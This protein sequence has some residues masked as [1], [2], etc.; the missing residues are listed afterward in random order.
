MRSD[1]RLFD[2][3]R[4]A[5]PEAWKLAIFGL[6]RDNMAARKLLHRALL[7]RREQRF[8][9]QYLRT[10]SVR[11]WRRFGDSAETR[12][13]T[14][15]V[16]EIPWVLSRHNGE[17]HVLDVGSS[18]APPVYISALTRLGIKDL[19]GVD[20]AN[21]QLPGLNVVHA[22][23]RHMPFDRG[24]F[25]LI[26]CISTLEHIG[27]DG[28]SQAVEA[29]DLA[30]LIEMRRVLSSNG[31]ILVSVPFGKAELHPWFRQYDRDGWHALIEAAGLV[32]LEQ[33]FYR[34]STH[35]G[36]GETE[37]ANLVS[38]SYQSDGAPAA[39]GLLCA[40]LAATSHLNG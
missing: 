10:A 22:D 35:A 34:Y 20:I 23:V 2:R 39:T 24:H 40:S 33:S 31:R 38:A 16:V 6:I 12:G 14:E 4:L 13:F 9:E 25:E 30:A 7:S 1:K 37:A 27:R 5:I 19:V 15:R 29:G 32:A 8:I 17:Q 18:F 28:T 21:V 3:V 36:W 26:L 11:P